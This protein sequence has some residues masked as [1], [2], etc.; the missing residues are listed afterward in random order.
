MQTAAALTFGGNFTL[1][2]TNQTDQQTQYA[3]PD[4]PEAGPIAFVVAGNNGTATSASCVL[5]PQ[6]PLQIGAD[7]ENSETGAKTAAQTYVVTCNGALYQATVTWG[8]LA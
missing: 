8:G 6:V 2:A 5:Y 1:T 7:F 4:L 3:I